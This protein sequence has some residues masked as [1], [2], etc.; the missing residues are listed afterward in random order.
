MRQVGSYIYEEFVETQGTDVK[1][2]TVGPDYGHAEARKS[3][4]VD[5]KV[6][7]EGKRRT[8]NKSAFLI[9]NL[10]FTNKS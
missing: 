2:Y 4:V 1:V 7:N 9:L 10:V 6:S 3:P 8:R 5:G